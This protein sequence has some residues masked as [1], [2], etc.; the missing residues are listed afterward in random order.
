ML[1]YF[2][3][4]NPFATVGPLGCF[5]HYKDVAKKQFFCAYLFQEHELLSRWGWNPWPHWILHEEK[6]KA[7]WAGTADPGSVLNL[8]QVTETL[9]T[10]PTPSKIRTTPAG[11][12]VNLLKVI[13]LM[14]WK[15][16]VTQIL[17]TTTGGG[18]LFG[19]LNSDTQGCIC[20]W[21]TLGTSLNTL[22]MKVMLRL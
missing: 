12:A 22:S 8:Q 21:K 14:C 15:G 11:L 19:A 6:V 10:I 16:E 13:W 20:L 17:A 7:H 4:W 3:L 9:K 18:M 2:N 5:C 1:I